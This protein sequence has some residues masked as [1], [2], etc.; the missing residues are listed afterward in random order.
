MSSGAGET[1]QW[2]R[3]DTESNCQHL[4]RE[5][6]LCLYTSTRD[7]TS[8]HPLRGSHICVLAHTETQTH[9]LCDKQW[10]DLKG[11][12]PSLTLRESAH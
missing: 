12:R 4:H 5:A 9:S 6:H 2:L 1:V 11:T 3:A 8:S 7:L 10:S